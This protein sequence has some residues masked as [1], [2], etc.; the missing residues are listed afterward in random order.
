MDLKREECLRWLWIQPLLCSLLTMHYQRSQEEAESCNAIC[1][2]SNSAFP[3]GPMGYNSSGEV[4][5]KIASHLTTRLMLWKECWAEQCSPKQFCTFQGM[6]A[7]FAMSRPRNRQGDALQGLCQ[8][9]Q[10]PEVHSTTLCFGL[11]M[12]FKAKCSCFCSWFLGSF[13]FCEKKWRLLTMGE[14]KTYWA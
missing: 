5:S 13:R 11:Q 10:A 1:H 3:S 12:D 8:A 6:C 7:P 4:N 9:L 2:N 14:R